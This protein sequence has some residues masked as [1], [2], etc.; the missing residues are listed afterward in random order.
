[1]SNIKNE[2]TISFVGDILCWKEQNDIAY[3]YESDDYDYSSSFKLISK[4]L[5]NSDYVVGNLETTLSGIEKKYT[6]ASET[7]PYSRIMFNTP[8]NFAE[9]LKTAGFDLLT[10]ANNHCMDRGSDGTL[11]TLSVLEK[12]SLE[13]IGTYRSKKDR[14][15]VFIKNIGGFKVAFLNY[16]HGINYYAHN[17]SISIDK[18]YLVNLLARPESQAY[19]FGTFPIDMELDKIGKLKYRIF[20]TDATPLDEYR[21]RE[22]LEDIEKVKVENP[23]IIIVLPHMGI[24]YR[25]YPSRFSKKWVDFLFKAG[26][27]VIIASHPHVLQPMEFKTI[28]DAD[29]SER[30][31]F[32]IYSM[33]NFI[34]S[35][36]YEPTDNALASV[37]LNLHIAR[38]QNDIATI[39]SI[40]FIP[41]WVQCRDNADNLN[42]RTISIYDALTDKEINRLVSETEIRKLPSIHKK[43]L[44][45]LSGVKYINMDMKCEYVITPVDLKTWN[46]K[47]F[48]LYKKV[49]ASTRIICFALSSLLRAAIGMVRG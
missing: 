22:V 48:F 10:T 23:D 40:S 45:L 9:A 19:E 15:A 42:I 21:C 28:V 36:L 12:Y 33:G 47:L 39:S 26:A 20:G 46:N 29:G 8:D 7:S 1:M 44:G 3:D 5:D 4:Y 35:P 43:L 49:I 18:Q 27:D 30:I 38:G 16:T 34:T 31:G 17:N 2:I 24:Q 11:R 32:V 14:D 41:T 6:Y 13:H 25:Q 37:I